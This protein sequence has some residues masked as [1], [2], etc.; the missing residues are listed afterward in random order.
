MRYLSFVFLIVFVFGKSGAAQY[1]SNL[2]VDKNSPVFTT[3]AAP[4][5]RSD[6]RIDQ[7]YR[8]M[9]TDP[10]KPLGLNSKNGGMI[11]LAF[12][13]GL[14]FK[15]KLKD[16]HQEPVITAS[17]SD[18]VKLYFEPF[19]NIRVDVDIAVYSSESVIID[20]TATNHG[21]QAADL[22]IFP[23][24]YMP[25]GKMQNVQNPENNAVIFHHQ[26]ER[27][28][29]M[30]NHDIPYFED[31]ISCFYVDRG[32]AIFKRFASPDDFYAAEEAANRGMPKNPQKAKLLAYA[33]IMQLQAGEQTKTR[34][35]R[36]LKP[37]T[38]QQDELMASCR[39]LEKVN[40]DDILQ[41]DIQ[42]YS[43]IPKLDFQNEDYRAVYYNAFN[44]M[45]QCMMPPEGES[46]YNYYVFSREPKWGWGYGG[47]VFHESL[48][49]LAYAFMDPLAAMNSQRVYMERQDTAGFINYRTGPYLNENIPYEGQVT[50][51]APW[52]NHQNF[53]LFRITADTAFLLEAYNSGKAYY[54]YYTA[55]RDQDGDGLAEWGAHA[56]LESVR[57]ARVAVWDKVGWPA[58][59]EGPDINA[60]LVMEARSLAAMAEILNFEE[61]AAK[62]K[63]KAKQRADLINRYLWDPETNFY[64]NVDRKDQD[65]TFENPEDL[66]I[67]EIIGFLPLWAGIPD[68]ER[69]A[70]LLQSMF[71]ENEFW[72]NYGIP[73]LSAE[74]HYYNP[75][76]YWNGPVWVQWNYLML[77]ALLDYGYEEQARLLAE[78]ILDNIIY[79][80]KTDHTFWEFYSADDL[81][82]GWNHT[83]IWTGIIARFMIDLHER[84]ILLQ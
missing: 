15:A 42:R 21:F 31:L 38:V 47:Q 44:L 6:Y 84:G 39:E 26:K 5:E 56:V 25:D 12:R 29:W 58:N 34:I 51:S 41:K 45:Q 24:F 37:D 71:N 27:D 78:K 81:Q 36:S 55:H 82:A 28:R 68:D 76:G 61:E 13:E 49:M 73:T 20:V 72:R 22:T 8:L 67:K 32:D 70:V 7:A 77:R 60:M 19:E 80:L 46:S 30:V 3:Y 40:L 10:E 16:L 11:G 74:H 63:K 17:Y 1:L 23:C 64:Y 33:L 69:A 18:L 52:Y 83:Y 50:S 43:R 59:F 48:V 2:H 4:V 54:E 14:K 79:H 75:I 9:W 35:I 57:D 53:E 65:F 62:F 66:K